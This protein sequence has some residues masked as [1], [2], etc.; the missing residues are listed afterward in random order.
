MEDLR[1]PIGRYTAQPFSEK[2]REEWLI[3]I[4]FLP[5]HLEN[6]VQNLDAAQLDT[7][8]REGGWTVKQVVH[9][10]AD[11]HMNSLIRFKLGLTE[12]N[13]TIKPYDENEWVKLADTQNLPVNVSLTLLHALHIRL[14][15]LL[16]NMSRT[17][18]DRTLFH[19]EHKKEFTLWEFLG[20][21]A[22]HG[23]HHTA[24]ITSLR[25]RMGW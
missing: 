16:K 19:P 18:L 24:H 8:Y 13:P 15:E 3:D 10:V 6:A 5:Q 21:Y 25:E 23:R 2:L 20:L 17:D 14:H 11:S 12:D 1:Y 4:Q 22:W 7:A 9:H